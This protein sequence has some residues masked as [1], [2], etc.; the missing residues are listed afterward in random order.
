MPDGSQ[1]DS[2]RQPSTGW[3]AIADVSVMISA[4]SNYSAWTGPDWI[5][6]CPVVDVNY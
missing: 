3:R 2:S 6:I 1:I 5:G 4:C